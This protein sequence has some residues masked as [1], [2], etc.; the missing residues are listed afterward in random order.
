MKDIKVLFILSILVLIFL[1]C[2][3]ENANQPIIEVING[4]EYIHNTGAPMYPEQTV[5]FIEEVTFGSETDKEILSAPFCIA[6]NDNEDVFIGD[7]KGDNIKVYKSNGEYLKKIGSKGQGPGEFQFISSIDFL[8]DDRLIVLDWLARRISF[9]DNNGDF[10]ESINTENSYSYIIATSD[11]LFY[12]VEINS[13]LK[14]NKRKFRE[15]N[16]KNKISRELFQIYAHNHIPRTI[17][18]R[19]IYLTQSDSP[20]SVVCGDKNNRLLYHCRGESFEIDVY[21]YSGKII[22]KIDMPYPRVAISEEYKKLQNEFWENR[23]KNDSYNIEVVNAY[24]TLPFPEFHP[25]TDNMTVDNNGNVWIKLAEI[26][27]I[28]GIKYNAFS[29]LDKEG[30]Y[31]TEIW[32][33]Y[34]PM[35]FFKDKMYAKYEDKDT[36]IVYV[37]K[38]D[39]IWK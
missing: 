33:K 11:S 1:F 3:K 24:L 35:L 39:V 30:K 16:I 34:T 18:G 38:I 32:S 20:A 15:L 22:K 14:G 26:N 25:V 21:D 37:K 6:V 31:I 17:Y 13:S 9:F 36:D 10:I 12:L 2:G 29:I 7:E 4:V 8:N 19:T 23:R 28:D 5:E 27:E